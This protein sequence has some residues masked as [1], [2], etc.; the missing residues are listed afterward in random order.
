MD[1]YQQNQLS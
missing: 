1:K